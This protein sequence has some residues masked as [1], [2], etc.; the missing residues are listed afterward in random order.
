MSDLHPLFFLL[1]GIGPGL[2]YIYLGLRVRKFR[3]VATR[4]LWLTLP[5]IVF[6]FL[7]LPG[8]YFYEIETEPSIYSIIGDPVEDVIVTMVWYMFYVFLSFQFVLHLL[9]QTLVLRAG[10]HEVLPVVQRLLSYRKLQYTQDGTKFNIS[11]LKLNVQVSNIS[12]LDLVGIRTK[13][14]DRKMKASIQEDLLNV[15]KGTP[16]ERF[17]AHLILFGI[18]IMIGWFLFVG[19]TFLQ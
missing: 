2:C 1:A 10:I 14:W 12:P 7:L 8:A 18:T 4:T 6:L 17:H 3:R 13:G 11:T 15:F 5:F 16:D 9:G 19:G